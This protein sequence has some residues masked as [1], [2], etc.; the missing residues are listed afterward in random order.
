[1]VTF[2]HHDTVG[3]GE[4]EEGYAGHP[5]VWLHFCIRHGWVGEREEGYAGH[6][7]VWLHFCIMTQLGV[8]EGWES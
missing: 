8:G 1:M 4:R 2:L 5:M 6:P 3:G 7:V